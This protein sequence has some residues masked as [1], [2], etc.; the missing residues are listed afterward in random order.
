MT[1]QWDVPGTS[2]LSQKR[3]LSLSIRDISG[4][5]SEEKWK[6]SWVEGIDR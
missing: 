6:E 1:G 5:T 2:G 4:R 3:L